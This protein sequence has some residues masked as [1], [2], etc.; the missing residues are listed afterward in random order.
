MEKRIATLAATKKSM[1]QNNLYFKKSFGQNFITDSQVLSNM[2]SLADLQPEDVVLEIGPGIGS[3]TQE[4]AEHCA[5]VTAVEID[6]RLIP[7]LSQNL[8]QY[9]NIDILCQDILK[10][11]LPALIQT[12]GNGNPIKVIANLPYYITTPILMALLECAAPIASITVMVQ[13]EVAQRLQ[14]GPGTK[15]Y[16]SLSVAV[17]YYAKPDGYFVVPAACFLPKPNVDSAVIS[18][19][20]TQGP[21]VSVE[22][23]ALLFQ[24]I[25][26]A[27]GQ[28]RKTLLNCLKKAAFLPI[29]KEAIAQVLHEVSL[30]EDIRG[31]KLTIHD[32]AAL[33]N[34]FTHLLES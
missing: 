12:I 21:Q 6:T 16:G 18:L 11:D 34:A 33:A 22:N 19:S 8:L 31:E 15:A 10:T 1:E 32:F 23:E 30:P 25:R 13:K 4:L 7:V 2:L 5:H 29:E 20:L 24:L 27:F 28:R 17:S 9:S 3:L 26:C 14:A